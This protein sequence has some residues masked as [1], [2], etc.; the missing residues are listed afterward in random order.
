VHADK[1]IDIDS[2]VDDV[3]KILTDD[4]SK[5]RLRFIDRYKDKE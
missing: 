1:L 4:Q 5:K 2:P 3:S